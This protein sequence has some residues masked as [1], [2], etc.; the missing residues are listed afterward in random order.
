MD[1]LIDL[2][3]EEDE[4]TFVAQNISI[5]ERA[6]AQRNQLIKVTSIAL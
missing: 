4:D 5:F 3:I 6:D 2:S 1:N